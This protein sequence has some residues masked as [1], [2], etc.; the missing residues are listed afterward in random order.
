MEHKFYTIFLISQ[1]K[2]DGDKKFPYLSSGLSK[3]IVTD[4]FKFCLMAYQPLWVI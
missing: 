1:I 3:S 2:T 4:E